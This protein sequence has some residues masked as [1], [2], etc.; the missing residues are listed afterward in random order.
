M[1]STNAFPS[2]LLMIRGRFVWH[3]NIII[4]IISRKLV[5][6]ESNISS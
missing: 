2:G 1:G 6:S 5:N 3:E 4:I